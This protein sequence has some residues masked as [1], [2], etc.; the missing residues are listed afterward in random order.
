MTE[1][2]KMEAGRRQSAVID[3]VTWLHSLRLWSPGDWM[4][5]ARVYCSACDA[6][7]AS[8]ART[9]ASRLPPL[10]RF[11]HASEQSF[12]QSVNERWKRTSSDLLAHSLPAHRSPHPI[13]TQ[14]HMEGE[15][16]Q[17]ASASQQLV[18]AAHLMPHLPAIKSRSCLCERRSDRE[19]IEAIE[20]ESGASLLWTEESASR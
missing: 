11:L 4:A 16:A 9:G 8:Q 14:C 15:A 13:V 12:K 18:C 7:P 17:L 10:L 19:A 20:A 1:K 6:H 2:D 5:C 3:R